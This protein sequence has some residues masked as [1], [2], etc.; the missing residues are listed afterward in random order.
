MEASE[1]KIDDGYEFVMPHL[2]I[3]ELIAVIIA[4]AGLLA[5]SLLANA[6]LLSIADPNKTENPAK[7]PWYF[8]GLQELL[9][10]FDPWI[11]G[12]TIPTIIIVGLML[13]PYLDVRKTG[14]GQYSFRPRMPEVIFFVFGFAMWIILILVGQFLRG[15]NWQFYWPWEDW[16][17]AK[18][19]EETLAN[20]SSWM[21]I[22]FLILYFGVGFALPALLCKG[23]FRKMG[24]ARYLTAIALVLL[25]Y[26]VVVKIVLRLVFNI[27]YILTTPWFNI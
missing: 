7:A 25:M 3:K 26:G 1:K 9:V 6:P 11:A 5:W 8:V 15:P 10:Y 27:R 24:S 19:A 21:G 17:V 2:V 22:G 18:S 23:L 14:A 16:S 20:M 12:V 4:S 13:L